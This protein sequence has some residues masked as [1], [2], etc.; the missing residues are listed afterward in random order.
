MNNKK[1][2]DD[3][4]EENGRDWETKTK[5]LINEVMDSGGTCKPFA[6]RSTP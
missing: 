6:V 4:S 1:V 3:E 5:W 2:V